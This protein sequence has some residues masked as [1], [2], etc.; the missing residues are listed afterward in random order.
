MLKKIEAMQQTNA[1]KNEKNEKPEL[2]SLK[3]SAN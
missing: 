2:L 1:K 3:K